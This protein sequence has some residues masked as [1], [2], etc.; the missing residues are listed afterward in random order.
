[1]LQTLKDYWEEFVLLPAPVRG[2]ISLALIVTF[3]FSCFFG[4]RDFIAGAKINRLEKENFELNRKTQAAL[5]KAAKSE[6]IAADE[7]LRAESLENQIK[8]LE[9]K[10]KTKDEQIQN[11]SQLGD[12]L[13]TRLT[14][15]RVSA[16][17]NTSTE[18]LEER[19]RNR[20]RK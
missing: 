17:A 2:F 20:Y 7:A 16:P 4:V 14:R 5:E 3:A 9:A 6:R 15:V 11:Q 1:M 19:L 8:S 18:R 12:N 10:T 13:R